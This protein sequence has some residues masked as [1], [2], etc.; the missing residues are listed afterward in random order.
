MSA[1]LII[2]SYI[3]GIFVSIG[4][5]EAYMEGKGGWAANQVGWKIDLGVGFLR[6]PLDAY[7]FWC[8]VVMIPMF[9][10]LPFIMFG[11]NAHLFWLVIIGALLGIV[12]EDFLWFVINPIFPFRDFKPEKVWWHYWIGFGKYKIPE[13]YVI[14]PLLAL[15]IWIYLL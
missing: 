15:F 6:K 14:F 11:W 13:F 12:I 8:W 2:L 1:D 3:L 10:M 5:W 9:L 4:F 7:H